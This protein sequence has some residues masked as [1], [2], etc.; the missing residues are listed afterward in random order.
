[1][2]R[3]T[4][5]LQLAL[6]LTSPWIV[7]KADFDADAR[8]LDMHIDFPPGARFAC[9][10]CAAVNC[11]AQDISPKTWRHLNF[12]QHQAFLHARVPRVRCDRCCEKQATVPWARADNGFT[13]LFEALIMALISAMPVAAAARL[14]GATTQ[15]YRACCIIMWNKPAHGWTPPP[16]TTSR[17]TRPPPA[18]AMLT[19]AWLRGEPRVCSMVPILDETDEDARGRVGERE[20]QMAERVS[21]VNRF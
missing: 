17:T 8:R 10:S 7:T 1:M 15:G 21:L 13:L 6:G 5:L 3:D 9:P 11:P 4:N 20:D 19:W 2:T 18:V 12:F 14:V 16:S